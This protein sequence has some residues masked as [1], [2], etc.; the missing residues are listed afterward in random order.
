M[1]PPFIRKIMMLAA[2]AA[3]AFNFS[4]GDDSGFVYLCM[5][6][7]LLYFDIRCGSILLA[8]SAFRR[9]DFTL[10]RRLINGTKKPQWLRPASKS[11]YYFLKGILCTIEENYAEAKACYLQAANKHLRPQH[12]QCLTYCA[13]TDMSLHL[14]E[15]D[16]AKQYLAKAKSFPN[17][18]DVEQMISELDKRMDALDNPAEGTAAEQQAEAIEHSEQSPEE[19]TD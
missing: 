12:L 15:Y 14:E 2:F 3:A 16:D 4:K 13:L 17:Q 1:F 18:D 6:A 5:G 9:Q 7:L 19:K 11:C 8:Y 10:L